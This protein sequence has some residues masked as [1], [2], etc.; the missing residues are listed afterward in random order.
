MTMDTV[1]STAFWSIPCRR[2]LG[3]PVI[4]ARG[5]RLGRR[6]SERAAPAAGQPGPD[7]ACSSSLTSFLPLDPPSPSPFAL[8]TSR[9]IVDPSR[10]QHDG[11]LLRSQPPAGFL[12][13]RRP[14]RDG[15]DNGSDEP[16]CL[17]AGLDDR[18]RPVLACRGRRPGFPCAPEVERPAARVPGRAPSYRTPVRADQQHVPT[19]DRPVSSHR[20]TAV[21]APGPSSPPSL[22]SRCSYG[23]RVR[24]G[25]ND[26]GSSASLG[27]LALT[28]LLYTLL[29]SSREWSVSRALRTRGLPRHAVDA[30]PARC[31]API[32]HQLS[33]C[34]TN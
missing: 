26:V 5:R 25:S 10:A 6:E 15:D 21:S 9:R 29:L 30:A 32:R 11:H 4:V 24:D 1:W 23:A 7:P 8:L 19:A 12:R 17:A 33:L 2:A 31:L 34:D 14:R 3:G 27:I 16:A 18:P 22:F 13:A 28:M 20:R